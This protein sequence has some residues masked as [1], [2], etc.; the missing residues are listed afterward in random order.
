MEAIPTAHAEPRELLL[1][2]TY[3]VHLWHP[4]G[5]SWNLDAYILTGAETVS[6]ALEW[7]NE[8]MDPG[9]KFELF[10]ETEGEY[11]APP[12]EPRK[13][14]LIRLLGEDPTDDAHPIS[15]IMTRE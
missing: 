7:V 3:R 9:Q 14:G 15:T 5:E 2:P 12:E 10:V 11:A 6:Q 4:T 13:A 8:T 1:F